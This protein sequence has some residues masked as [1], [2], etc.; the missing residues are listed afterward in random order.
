MK[1]RLHPLHFLAAFILLMVTWI[2]ARAQ[3]PFIT[4]NVPLGTSPSSFTQNFNS[5]PQP[6]GLNLTVSAAGLLATTG[7]GIYTNQLL[8]QPSTGAPNIIGVVPLSGY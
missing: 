7:D 2:G 1:K 4:L 3:A 5:L 6:G 8:L